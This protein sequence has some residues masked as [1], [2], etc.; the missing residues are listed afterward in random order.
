[1]K[2]LLYQAA[3][4]SWN[5]AHQTLQLELPRSSALMQGSVDETLVAWLHV[6]AH[7]EENHARSLRK[8]AKQIK[9]CANKRGLNQIVLHSFA[10]LGGSDADPL[11]AH[12]LLD[13]LEERLIGNGY[14]LYRTPFGWFCSWKLDV[15]GESL[16]KVFVSF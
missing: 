16:A 14:T 5:A 9:W 13:D 7:D 15:Y 2:A 11:Y 10:H 1:M 6:E 12:R 4:F 3:H 8:I